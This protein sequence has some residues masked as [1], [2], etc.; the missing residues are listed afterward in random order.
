MPGGGGQV[1]APGSHVGV[2]RKVLARAVA[3]EPCE[4]HG[5]VDR[6]WNRDL[7]SDPEFSGDKCGACDGKG[8]KDFSEEEEDLPYA[9][10]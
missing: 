8:T 2:A 7:G 4:G 5:E 6:C 10:V 9:L 3:C 1:S